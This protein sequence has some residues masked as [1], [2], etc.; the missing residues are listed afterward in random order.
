[1][2][3]E[4][5][6]AFVSL[7]GTRSFTQTAK[8]L[9]VA[10]ST[11]TM[12]IKTL[13]EGLGKSLFV[14]DN[15][16]VELTLAGEKLLPYAQRIL[17]LAK[18]GKETTLIEEQ[19]DGHLVIGSLHSLWDFVI[20]PIISEFRKAHPRISLRLVSGHSDDI[21]R[22]IG[23]RIVDAGLVYLPP[24]TPEIEVVPLFHD[25]IC[26]VAH[27]SFELQTDSISVSELSQYPYIHL[28]WGHPFS[29][30]YETEAGGIRLHPL[31]VDHTSLL[32]KFIMSEKGVGFLL[33]SVADTLIQEGKLKQIRLDSKTPPPQR[34][35][36]LIYPK[37]KRNSS[38]FSSWL[39]FITHFQSR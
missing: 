38:V 36:Y 12:R 4:Q 30:W 13:E 24:R 29:E 28:N 39:E 3:M 6:E 22:K 2:E 23:D 11:V 31:Q 8:Q 33:K 18:E 20:F 7:A 1:M 5:L 34:T 10:Q 32:L 16:R 9:H 17:D 35:T 14:R 27:P 25:S 21:V 37:T 19:F 26:L 15:K